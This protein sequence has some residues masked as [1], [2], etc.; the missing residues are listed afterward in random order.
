[1][2]IDLENFF[3]IFYLTLHQQFHETIP[4]VLTET[5]PEYFD[6]KNI[7][8]EFFEKGTF[9]VLPFKSSINLCKLNINKTR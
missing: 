2:Y 4:S 5:G 8:R 1:M 6:I 7:T 9:I 3:Q